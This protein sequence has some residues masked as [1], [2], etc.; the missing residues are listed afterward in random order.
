MYICKGKTRVVFVFPKL[1]L[2]FKL[3]MIRFLTSIALTKRN[4]Q[5]YFGGNPPL[6][7]EDMGDVKSY[8]F[9]GI[10]KNWREFIFYLKTRHPIL[11]PTFFSL[12][13]F[14]NI[15]LAGKEQVK[16]WGAILSQATEILFDSNDDN[17]FF[18]SDNHHWMN[19]RNFSIDDG[20]LKMLDYGSKYTQ[21]T[22]RSH[23]SIIIA[24]FN[25]S[26]KYNEERYLEKYLAYKARRKI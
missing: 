18:G 8:L 21:K 3:P 22:I 7:K 2:V 5:R 25:P 14:F 9:G 16:E 10:L 26:Y 24:D 17:P 11:Q 12:F 20:K 23:G 1:G 13:G 6:Q 15:Q 4:L 19:P